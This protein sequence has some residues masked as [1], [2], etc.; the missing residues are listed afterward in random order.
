MKGLA[1]K[2]R[3]SVLRKLSKGGGLKTFLYC[4]EVQC[5]QTAWRVPLLPSLVISSTPG[6][7]VVIGIL[8][9]DIEKKRYEIKVKSN[10][11]P[12]ELE[13]AKLGTVRTEGEGGMALVHSVGGVEYRTKISTIRGDWRKPDG[14]HGNRLRL[15]EKSDFMPRPED[16]YQERLYAIRWVRPKEN[17]KGD[18]YEFRA[19]TTKDL[20][21]EKV[22]Q[23]Y[24]K[25]HLAEWQEKGYVPEVR[26]EEGRETSRPIRER[27]WTYWHHL[28]NPRQ[29]LVAGLVNQ[30]KDAAVALGL[31]KL[32]NW[33]SR[34]SIWKCAG[35]GGGSVQ[36][37]FTNQALNT[38]FNFGCRSFEECLPHLRFRNT[39]IPFID[40]TINLLKCEPI[41][42]FS[43][44]ADLFI[45]DPPYGDAVNY[46][47]ILEFFI[48]WLRK[49][50]PPEFKD[51]TWD[52]RRILAIKGSDEAFRQGMVAGYKRLAERMPDNGIQVLMFTHQSGQL[53]AD[54]ANI[55]WASGLRVTA[56][57]YV[58]T[59][60]E[61]ALREGSYV[62]GTVLLVLRKGEATKKT[63]RDEL[64]WEIQDEVERQVHNW[65]ASTKER[66]GGF[67]TKMFLRMQTSRWLV[68][69]RRF[70][71]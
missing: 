2:L 63:S 58:V 55:V 66:R 59:E 67:G 38:L 10:P 4:L 45:T 1:E 60:T 52:S 22:V 21:K 41:S 47:E 32:L 68:M 71:F 25:E 46:E 33:N 57:W 43:S 65:S 34:L 13:T 14:S 69:R 61:S 48:A 9:P 27:G 23:D 18:E 42:F 16:I 37:A 24:I 44:S 50:P 53:W 62:K 3:N 19:V 7:P 17:G 54:M 6:K 8:K 64:A 49:N 11:S 31:C 51:W 15:W 20:E 28:F 39:K 70:G 36:N 56:A 35:G 30:T 5:P 29:L 40:R 12:E 26:I